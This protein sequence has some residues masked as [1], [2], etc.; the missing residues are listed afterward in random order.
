[1]ASIYSCAECGTNLNLNTIHL[2]PADFYFEAGNK[3]TL[4]FSA[5]DA[6]KFRFEKE[7]KF[8]PFFETIDYWGIQRNRTKIKCNGCGRLVGHVYDDGPPLTDS[9]VKW[10]SLLSGVVVSGLWCLN[11]DFNVN[12]TQ[13]GAFGVMYC[14]ENHRCDDAKERKKS[15]VN[16]KRLLKTSEAEWN[17]G[18]ITRHNHIEIL[19]VIDDVLTGIDDWGVVSKCLICN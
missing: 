7:D 8:R 18:T 19:Q 5:T 15:M 2:Y 11:F 6:T 1:M 10:A 9:P 13:V 12:G 17:N 16:L 4:S 14:I 3:G